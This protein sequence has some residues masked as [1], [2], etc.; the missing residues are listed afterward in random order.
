VICVTNGTKT[1]EILDGMTDKG[2]G[3]RFD[4]GRQ[5]V[6]EMSARRSVKRRE[7]KIIL[8][9]ETELIKRKT[10]NLWDGMWQHKGRKSDQRIESETFSCL[11]SSRSSC[12]LFGARL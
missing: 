10:L 1:N 9:L 2:R 8:G 7:F 6:K 3:R 4:G 5:K 12:P 11:N